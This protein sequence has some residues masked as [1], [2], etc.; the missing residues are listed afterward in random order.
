ML[1]PPAA[2]A[3]LHFTTVS[4]V[5]LTTCLAVAHEIIFIVATFLTHSLVASC[6]DRETLAII[7]TQGL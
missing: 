5:M 1:V 2:I 3:E 7:I 6:A 4:T